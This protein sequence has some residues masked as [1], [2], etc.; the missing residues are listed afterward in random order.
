MKLETQYAEF[1]LRLLLEQD[2]GSL[3]GHPI[4]RDLQWDVLL[5][6]ARRNRVTTRV[7]DRLLA[8]GVQPDESYQKAVNEEKVRIGHVIELMGKI[9]EICEGAGIDFLFVKNYQHYPDMGED[10]DLFVM[11]YTDTADV[12]VIEKL[13]ARPCKLSLLNQMGGKTQYYFDGY[14]AY[15][16]IHHGRIG[17]MGEH[18]TL[19]YFLMRN[20]K[21]VHIDDVCIFVPGLDDQLIIQVLQSVYGHFYLRISEMAYCVSATRERRVNWDYIV[22][23][24][25]KIGIFEGLRY[26][27]GCVNMVY[28]NVMKEILPLNKSELL[29]AEAVIKVGFRGFYYRLPLLTVGANL[30]SK[31]FFADIWAL[32]WIGAGR[33][34]LAPFFAMVEG[35]KALAQWRAIAP[36]T[37]FKRN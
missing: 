23:T 32:N 21:S 6:L 22:E 33:L 5:E 19:P 2:D 9:G 15:L 29:D 13:G 24:T 30:Y 25:R 10:I 37:R 26:Y 35:L 11:D 12:A 14:P 20:R 8:R 28:Q 3:S 36:S 16:E 1:M 17:R 31:K 34:C 18:T 7:H 4:L 27:L